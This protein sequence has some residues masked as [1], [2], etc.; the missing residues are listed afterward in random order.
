MMEVKSW[1]QVSLSQE[2]I[3]QAIHEYVEK[4]LGTKIVEGALEISY[5]TTTVSLPDGDF[6]KVLAQADIYE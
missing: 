3:N 4:K 2:E 1:K 5:L 6:T